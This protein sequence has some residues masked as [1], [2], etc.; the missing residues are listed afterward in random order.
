MRTEPIG[1]FCHW[2]A[3][4]EIVEIAYS[5]HGLRLLI[6][7]AQES[8]AFVEVFF[9]YPRAFQV[10]DEGDM[11]AF[12]HEGGLEQGYFVFKVLEGGWASRVADNFLQT[13]LAV[14]IPPYEEWLIATS[15]LCASVIS[16]QTP[17]VRLF[18]GE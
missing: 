3:G 7:R 13:T 2:S 18:S 15:M 6:G 11:L 5:R 10:M 8:E 14:G 1:A 9:Q 17:L 16:P 12:W 4:A